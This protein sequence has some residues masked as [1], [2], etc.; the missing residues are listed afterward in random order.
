[1]A[2]KH[3]ELMPH[4]GVKPQTKGKP[5]NKKNSFYFNNLKYTKAGTPFAK[6]GL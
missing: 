3:R 2:S 6:E 1:M 5:F 4:S